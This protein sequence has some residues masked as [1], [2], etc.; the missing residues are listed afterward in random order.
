MEDRI[1][2]LEISVVE[3]R[4]DNASLAKSVEHLSES[5][6]DLV[7]VVGTL[8]DTMNKG[9]GALWMLL[10][11]SAVMGGVLSAIAKKLLF[12]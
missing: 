11:A 5:V 12:Q 1:Q 9:R 10:T 4:V 2:R 3:L 8:R 7:T 6:R